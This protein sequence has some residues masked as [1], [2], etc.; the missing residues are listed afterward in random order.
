[1]RAEPNASCNN[2]R[3]AAHRR[4]AG[5]LHRPCRRPRALLRTKPEYHLQLPIVGHG[6]PVDDLGEPGSGC[7]RAHLLHQYYTPRCQPTV[8]YVLDRN[9]RARSLAGG[10]TFLN[11]RDG[12][13][14]APCGAIPNQVSL[15]RAGH[16]GAARP[17]V[18]ASNGPGGEQVRGVVNRVYEAFMAFARTD[19]Y[20]A[21]PAALGCVPD[22]LAQDLQHAS[23]SLGRHAALSSRDF[24]LRGGDLESVPRFIPWAA[25]R[26]AFVQQRQGPSSLKRT[27]ES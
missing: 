17:P 24:F 9:R 11:G 15:H 10:V 27:T 1:M 14:Q 4:A 22:A 8:N 13:F 5:S 19:M 6:S 7:E 25:S 21:L 2:P 16:A 26:N 20:V 23:P 12:A 3:I 18:C